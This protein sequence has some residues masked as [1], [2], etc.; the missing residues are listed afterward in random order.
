MSRSSFAFLNKPQLV[1]RR[2][3]TY[4]VSTGDHCPTIVVQG[5]SFQGEL[6]SLVWKVG[7]VT[8]KHW[9]TVLS[10]LVSVQIC[11]SYW[12]S[13][14]FFSSWHGYNHPTPKLQSLSFPCVLEDCELQSADTVVSSRWFLDVHLHSYFH[15]S[16]TNKMLLFSTNSAD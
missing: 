14:V 2:P 1:G 13:E 6:S 5:F 15:V 12:N 10:S 4:F 16:T 8:Q 11:S 3:S 7:G 9:W